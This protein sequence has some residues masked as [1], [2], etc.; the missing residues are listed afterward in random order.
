MYVGGGGGCYK[1]KPFGRTFGWGWGR[2][3]CIGCLDVMGGYPQRHSRPVYSSTV[4]SWI[5]RRCIMSGQCVQYEVLVLVSAPSKEEQHQKRTMVLE[6][7]NSRS[8]IMAAASSGII[9]IA[10]TS[11]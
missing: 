5:G 11:Q 2:I 8:I 9:I 10:R 4:R 3:L 6:N 7:Y 1:I